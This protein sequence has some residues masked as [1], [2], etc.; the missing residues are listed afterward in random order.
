MDK[1]EAVVNADSSFRKEAFSE[2]DI[3]GVLHF[4][5]DQLRG[6]IGKFMGMQAEGIIFRLVVHISAVEAFKGIK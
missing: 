3:F 2:N 1:A 4:G 6:S 5:H